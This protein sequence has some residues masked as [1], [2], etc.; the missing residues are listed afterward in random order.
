MIRVLVG[1]TLL[2]FFLGMGGTA[3]LAFS[4]PPSPQI[5]AASLP[6]NLTDILNVDCR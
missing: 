5:D 2:G 1:V 4:G 6:G 3:L